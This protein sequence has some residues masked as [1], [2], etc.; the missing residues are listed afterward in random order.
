MT[1]AAQTIGKQAENRALAYLQAQGLSLCARNF[2]IRR[3]EIDLI[4]REGDEIAFIEVRARRPGAF[5]DGID[6]VT[7]AKQRRLVAAA[8]AWLQR[9][10]EQP[11]TR[12]DVVG[13]AP[14]DELIW[15]KDAFRPDD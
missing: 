5:G 4:M 1:T 8:S 15:I 7:R 12:F 9:Q 14:G 3:G 2:Q 13:V 10:R 11:A 6:S